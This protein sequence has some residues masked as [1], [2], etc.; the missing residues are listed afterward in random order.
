MYV[1]HFA[2]GLALKARHPR[3][4]ALPIMLG[5]GFLD[6][7][8]GI[9]IALGWDRVTPNLRAEPYVFFDLTFIDWDHSLVA[10]LF[11]SA[12]WGAMFL[13]DKR[14]A[15]VAFFAAISHFVSDWLMHNNDLALFPHS[16]THLGF[17]LWG[18]LGTASWVLEGVFAAALAVYAW[19]QSAKRGVSLLWPCVALAALFLNLSPWLS[20]MKHVATLSEPAAHLLNGVLV[21][22]GFLLPGALMI[23][24]IQRS[25]KE[26]GAKGGFVAENPLA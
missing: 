7:L 17:N 3:I 25:E 5:V 2:I 20:P 23:W 4:P 18:K 15:A 1:G 13:K 12:V 19:V 24:L 22:T 21:T 9:F 11:W 26:A 6:L 16:Q 10:A 14:V 8:N